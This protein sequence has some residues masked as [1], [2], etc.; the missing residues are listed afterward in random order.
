[1]KNKL[2][3]DTRTTVLGHVQRGGSPSAY[4]RILGCRMG[5]EATLALMQMTDVS[6]PCVICTD[7]SQMARLSLMDC[8]T[9]TQAVQAA[10]DNKL[11]RLFTKQTNSSSYLK[12]DLRFSNCLIK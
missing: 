4:D 3:F 9:R 12:D 11:I 7:G 8:V 2:G 5:A 10:M 1:M 6:Q